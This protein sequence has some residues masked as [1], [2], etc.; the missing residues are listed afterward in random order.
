MN[1]YNFPPP[2]AGNFEKKQMKPVSALFILLLLQIHTQ[3]QSTNNHMSV[4]EQNKQ[5]VQ[6]V[7]EQALNKRNLDLL[8]NMVSDE[9][10]GIAGK[11]GVEAFKEPIHMILK[12]LPDAQWNIRE[13]IAEGD[14]VMVRWSV[15]GTSKGPFASFAASGK[16][17]ATEGMGIYTIKNGK[18]IAV[19][20]L[21][22]RLAFLQQLDVL[23]ADISVLGKK[24]Q[25]MFIDKFLVPTAAIK[26]FRERMQIN[27]A[28]IRKLPGFIKDAAYE[29][30]NDEG[31]LVCVTIA[32]WQSREDLDKAREAVQE[33]YKKQG[34]DA[35][36]LF[37]RLNISADRGIYTV[38][39][40]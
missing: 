35:A 10:T 37:K 26:E 17:A 29:Y 40:D 32:Q 38:V 7:Y 18:I 16:K 30:T 21:T 31:N 36:A 19:H 33:E 28:F 9:Y 34:F 8:N 15:D 25:V 23:P 3:S 24:D 39:K 4:S 22:D 6:K 5:L 13:I 20:V 11:K 12:A 27:R 2:T 1:F 14:K